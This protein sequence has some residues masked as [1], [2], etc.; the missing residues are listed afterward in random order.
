[1]TH[2]VLARFLGLFLALQWL[3]C[4]GGRT[5]AE[6]PGKERECPSG[7]VNAGRTIVTMDCNTVV[8]YD[9]AELNASLAAVG[10]GNAGIKNVDTVLRQVSDAATEAQLQFTQ[11]C[12]VYN[13][14]QLTQPEFTAALQRAQERGRTLRER[15]ELLKA[16]GSKPEVVRAL[17]ADIYSQ[18]VP[19]PEREKQ[20][21]GL[22]FMV[23]AADPPGS[24]ARLLK[25][26]D[27][28]H[29]RAKLVFGLQVS[30]SAY[31]YVFERKKAQKTVDV[32]FPN[33]K[34]SN[35]QNPIPAGAQIRIPPAGQV[36]TVDDKDLGPETIV[37]AV[38]RE[39]LSNL[40]S[41]AAQ[42]SAE[43]QGEQQLG[44]AVTDLV[45]DGAPECASKTRGLDVTEQGCGSL[46]RGLTPTAASAGDDFFKAESSVQAQ[47][48][49]GDGLIVRTFTFNHVN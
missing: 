27:T 24:P 43:T 37:V 2:V 22:N 30:Q 28:L 44:Q 5:E 17:F 14:C 23:Q 31:A 21:F 8:Q 42:A 16:S 4:G 9:G 25:N 7:T 15:V 33:V 12:R 35:L 10:L 13:S 19:R 49:P 45:N 1:M 11:T 3:G 32:L 29:T 46:S 48:V 40:D 38:S 20:T 6:S 41:I 26:G 34:I 39:P 47:S 36:F 18:T